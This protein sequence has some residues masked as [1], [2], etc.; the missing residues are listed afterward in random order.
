MQITIHQALFG[1]KKDSLSLLKTTLPNEKLAHKIC[2][3]TDLSDRGQNWSPAIRGFAIEDNYIILKTYSDISPGMR[4]G[5]VFSHALIIEKK[6]LS[7]IN[8]LEV[9]YNHF[10]NEMNKDLD[11]QPIIYSDREFSGTI[12]KDRIIKAAEGLLNEEQIVWI[13]QDNF[14][15]AIA[16]LWKNFKA[17]TRFEFKFGINFNPTSV[18]NQ[19]IVCTPDFLLPKWQN[20]K[21][22]VVDKEDKVIKPSQAAL[23]L[24]SGDKNSN[25]HS[26]LEQ[27]GYE[28]TSLKQLSLLEKGLDTFTNL[29]SNNDF[30]EVFNLFNIL[31]VNKNTSE[32]KNDLIVK[33]IQRLIQIIPNVGSQSI[34]ALRK[35]KLT[36]ELIILKTELEEAIRNWSENKLFD[37]N[38]NLTND[39]GKVLGNIIANDSEEWWIK[40][41]KNQLKIF[42]SEWKKEY[43]P[44]VIKWLNGD[45]QNII[46][47]LSEFFNSAKEI[48]NDLQK[49]LALSPNNLN[50]TE[51]KKF[52][53]KNKWFVLHAR[54]LINS[55]AN[56]I[57]EEQL[58]IDS[59]DTKGLKLISENISG[60]L[61][62]KSTIKNNDDR[63]NVISGSL[64]INDR[65][66]LSEMNISSANWQKIL[67]EVIKIEP[68]LSKLFKKPYQDFLFPVF[69]ILIDGSPVEDDLLSLLSKTEY[70]DIKE[71]TNRKE[72]WGLLS[73][74]VKENFISA[75]VKSI[76]TNIDFLEAEYEDAIKKKINS[77]EFVDF[78]I[79]ANKSD[80]GKIVN[81]F[82][83]F[84]ISDEKFLYIFLQQTNTTFNS[85][86]AQKLGKLVYNKKWRNCLSIIQSKAINNQSF[87]VA[88]QDCCGLLSFFA[89]GNAVWQ[90]LITKV[91]IS[92]SDWWQSLED[93]LCKL[94]PEGPI[95]NKI[96]KRAGGDESELQHK[97][98]GKEMW[99]NS[100]HKLNNGGTKKITINN[101]LIETK[102]DFPNNNDLN[103]LI[104]IK[105]KI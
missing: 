23:F 81:L 71:Y 48:E 17:T 46:K 100:L 41:V 72:L 21:F 39:T 34:N 86:D 45:L 2:N 90:G 24:V 66:L 64:I 56:N 33:V 53:L 60:A 102:K 75:T 32:V 99:R 58:S 87:K 79:N 36:R 11:I 65:K 94:Y 27:I 76:S 103:I 38:F 40:T 59:K 70:R 83:K 28:P 35:L 50:D 30:N 13:G 85:I 44:F 47:A 8:N 18:S 20:T 12:D 96:W 95:D 7:R 16:T 19:N 73:E 92:N 25:F 61:F 91:Y 101:L 31:N 1:D 69:D 78:F 42:F 74:D 88:F 84:D 37:S 98:T 55:K 89:Y 51:F 63:L 22:C 77:N 10:Q 93:L 29:E 62:L 6:D 5:R 67:L 9:L 57:I 43:A 68:V 105:K 14:P 4:Q 15:N 80:V 49:Q 97:S 54:I 3:S 82:I 104:E 52:C 26:F